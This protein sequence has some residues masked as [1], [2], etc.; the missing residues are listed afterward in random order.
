[1]DEGDFERDNESPERPVDSIF[2]EKGADGDEAE[3]AEAGGGDD[4]GAGDAEED[5]DEWVVRV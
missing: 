3:N 1:M 2:T 4:E 5:E